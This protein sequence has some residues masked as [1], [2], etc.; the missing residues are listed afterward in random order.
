MLTTTPV[1]S[2]LTK[3]SIP[4]AETSN[5]CKFRIR[6]SLKQTAHN[7]R[8]HANSDSTVI[9]KTGQKC[10]TAYLCVFG[11]SPAGSTGQACC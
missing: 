10:C 4:T 11:A 8:A 7:V 3:L 1:P 6:D 2:L 9:S 5:R